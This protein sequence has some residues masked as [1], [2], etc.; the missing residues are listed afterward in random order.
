MFFVAFG[1]MFRKFKINVVLGANFCGTNLRIRST[2]TTGTS[3][4]LI[5][6]TIFFFCRLR[7]DVT[8]LKGSCLSM[9]VWLVLP[10]DITHLIPNHNKVKETNFNHTKTSK[11]IFEEIKVRMPRLIYMYNLYTHCNANHKQFKK[12]TVL[13]TRVWYAKVGCCLFFFEY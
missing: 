1:L 11:V 4:A 3:R 6:T 2:A 5:W 12:Y 8:I 7:F 10:A 13:P 9:F